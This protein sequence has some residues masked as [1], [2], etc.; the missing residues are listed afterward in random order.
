MTK[1]DCD[2]LRM[3]CPT[4]EAV[5]GKDGL[6]DTMKGMADEADNFRDEMREALHKIDKRLSRIE[7]GFMFAVGAWTFFSQILPALVKMGQAAAA[8][9]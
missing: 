9:H 8:T 4:R 6:R 5:S 7:W 1:E 2:R 3:E